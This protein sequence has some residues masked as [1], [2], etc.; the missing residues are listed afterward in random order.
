M[1]A[2][3]LQ[4]RLAA[5]VDTSSDEPPAPD[6]LRVLPMDMHEGVNLDLSDEA[7][8][9]PLEAVLEGAELLIVDNISTLVRSGREN[10]AESWSVVQQWALAQRR[11]GRSAVFIHHAAKGGQQR[12]TSR[13][14]DVLDTVVALKRPTDYQPDEGARFEVHFE[15]SRGFYGDEAKPFEASLTSPHGWTTRDLIDAD[16]AQV[17]ALTEDG[18]NVLAWC[19]C[20]RPLECKGRA[21]EFD[22]GATAVMCP[23]YLM[24]HD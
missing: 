8:H 15:K 6:Y 5:I 14:E 3:A 7:C 16:M 9:P 20:G 4:E 19:M 18:M 21:A 17:M 1:P 11:A 24:R 2:V 13:R 10:E 23:A 12:G 22:G